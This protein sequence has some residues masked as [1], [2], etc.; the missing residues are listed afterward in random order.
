LS[1]KSELSI[2][3]LALAFLT[4]AASTAE[5]VSKYSVNIAVNNTLGTYLVNQTGFSLYYFTK[6]AP[7]NGTSSCYG[8]CSK[9]WPPFYVENLTVAKGLNPADFTINNRS[10]GTKQIA[11]EG[12]PLYYYSKDA[13]PKDTNGQGANDVWFVI[14]PTFS[15]FGKITPYN[16]TLKLAPQVLNRGQS[17]SQHSEGSSSEGPM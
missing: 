16:F 15:P 8:N 13:K 11:Y 3:V 17:S 4:T 1:L 12:W 14:N 2:L 10:D 5:D 7:G 9:I 6:D